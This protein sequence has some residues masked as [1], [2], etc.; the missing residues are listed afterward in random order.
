MPPGLGL[1]MGSVIARPGSQGS[2]PDPRQK[3][4][5]CGHW[6]SRRHRK[7][8]WGQRWAK[9]KLGCGSA[10]INGHPKAFSQALAGPWNSRAG[11]Q[12][13]PAT[14]PQQRQLLGQL[15][16]LHPPL[17]F[18]NREG[19]LADAMVQGWLWASSARTQRGVLRAL[20]LTAE[21]TPWRSYTSVIA[22][23]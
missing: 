3:Q 2:S 20:E 22:C 6:D 18:I 1:P 7:P 16:L 13:K 11:A 12:A 23:F 5:S 21:L 17:P 10:G 14:H 8:P 4:G 19:P 9:A 15:S